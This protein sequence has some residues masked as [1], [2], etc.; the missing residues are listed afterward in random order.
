MLPLVGRGDLYPVND[1]EEFWNL[2]KHRRHAA[3]AQPG[4]CDVFLVR[5]G[6]GVCE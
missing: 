5:H 3:D 6:A 1:C 2:L 4:R